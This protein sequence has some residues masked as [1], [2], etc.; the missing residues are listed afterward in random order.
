MKKELENT[1]KETQKLIKENKTE[2]APR[3]EGYSKEIL[4]KLNYSFTKFHEFE[5]LKL[6]INIS[7]VKKST[8]SLKFDLRYLGQNVAT[9]KTT[10]NDVVISTKNYNGNN[11][12]HFGCAIELDNANWRGKEAREFRAFFK[13]NKK[14]RNDHGKKKEEH[15]LESSLLTE[16]TKKNKQIR[17]IRPVQ[18]FKVR[19]AV[20]TPLNACNHNQPA[21][22]AKE[23]GGAIDILARTG[24]GG[25]AT[26]LTIIEVKDKNKS[27]EPPLSA[28][29][30]AIK[31]AVF[32]RELL[33]SESG[34]D[35]YKIFGFNG[36]LPKH[37]RLRVACAM[38]DDVVDDSFA[39]M[40]FPID[41]DIIE[42]HYIYFKYIDNQLSNFQTSLKQ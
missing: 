16:F 1:I 35:W 39:G 36:E 33:R 34:A 10:K 7:Y 37:L 12:K 19:F 8:R 20:P 3:Y 40:T 30:Q 24:V 41:N 22:Y 17:R 32:I 9:I 29:K 13:N 4:D 18:L 27:Q 25:K 28:L 31:Y 14:P 15:A 21:R 6:Y 2:W 11:L 26:Y 23:K 38:P 42:C 5:P